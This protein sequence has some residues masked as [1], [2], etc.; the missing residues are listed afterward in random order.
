MSQWETQPNHGEI[1]DKKIN[2]HYGKLGVFFPG[3]KK[4]LFKK[5]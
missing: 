2:K 3:Y 1:I 5:N 4:E